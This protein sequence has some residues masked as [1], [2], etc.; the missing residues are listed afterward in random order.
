[1]SI[2]PLKGDVVA[3]IVYVPQHVARW[4][5][6]LKKVEKIRLTVQLASPHYEFTAWGKIAENAHADFL[7]LEGKIA[8]L[9][10]VKIVPT[11]G[12]YE[13]HFSPSEAF[14]IVECPLEST[15]VDLLSA[16]AKFLSFSE[17]GKESQ[18][19]MVNLSGYVRMLGDTVEAS[20][21][22]KPREGL[23]FDIVDDR[24]FLLR[25]TAFVDEGEPQYEVKEGV[26]FECFLACVDRANTR[27]VWDSE[28]T[29]VRFYEDRKKDNLSE[30][31]VTDV[32]WLEGYKS[33]ESICRQLQRCFLMQSV[34]NAAC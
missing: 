6:E 2:R 5:D 32:Q 20:R 34:L 30:L 13:E 33:K 16:T 26:Y 18:W 23:T 8:V 19:A 31:R 25:V 24:M 4:I 14:T 3:K 22:G 1:L 9:R 17:I 10:S 11:K 12:K 15:P 28:R 29:D 27:L 7:A 21:K